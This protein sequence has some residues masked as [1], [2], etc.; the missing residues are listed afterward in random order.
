MSKVAFTRKVILRMRCVLQVVSQETGWL[1]TLK[2]A[3][4]KR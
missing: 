2:F 3:R 1:I 4:S